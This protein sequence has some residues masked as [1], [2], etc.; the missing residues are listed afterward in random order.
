MK[1]FACLARRSGTAGPQASK[2][3]S[4]R[5]RPVESCD[6]N[7]FEEYLRAFDGNAPPRNENVRAAAG[8]MPAPW[9][10]APPTATL[11]NGKFKVKKNAFGPVNLELKPSTEMFGSMK[12]A[13]HHVYDLQPDLADTIL[14]VAGG[15]GG[16]AI[17]LAEAPPRRPSYLEEEGGAERYNFAEFGRKA[18]AVALKSKSNPKPVLARPA[19]IEWVGKSRVFVRERSSWSFGVAVDYTGIPIFSWFPHRIERARYC[20]VVL[21]TEQ[22]MAF[23][24]APPLPVRPPQDTEPRK[25]QPSTPPPWAAEFLNSLESWEDLLIPEARREIENWFLKNKLDYKHVV[26]SAEAGG[27]PHR[28]RLEVGKKDGELRLNLSAYVPKVRQ[29]ID[30]GF[31]IKI[32]EAGVLATQG[33]E[34]LPTE[35]F[36]YCRNAMLLFALSFTGTDF[37]DRRLLQTLIVGM[38]MDADD[39]PPIIAASPHHRGAREFPAMLR[40]I[41]N[42]EVQAGWITPPTCRPQTIPF[43]VTPVSVVEK[44]ESEKMRKVGDASHPRKDSFASSLGAYYLPPNANCRLGPEYLCLWGNPYTVARFMHV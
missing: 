10:G 12:W 38:D 16:A 8:K 21:A 42:E 3:I 20:F 5:L 28:L 41:V 22:L 23:V 36:G 34:M 13:M 43:R 44:P 39:T 19:P 26:Q 4:L 18:E 37:R 11:L 31:V 14:A 30:A 40:D 17:P 2:A 33:S 9:D 1:S 35:I 7:P 15:N 24:R 27:T 32:S 29:L 25:L 6:W